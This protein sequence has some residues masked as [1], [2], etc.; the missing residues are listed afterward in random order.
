MAAQYENRTVLTETESEKR[1]DEKRKV[2]KRMQ[3][4][5]KDKYHRQQQT[6]GWLADILH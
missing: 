1:K 3:E 4:L 6:A 5:H 2:S